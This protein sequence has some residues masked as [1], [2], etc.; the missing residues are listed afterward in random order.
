MSAPSIVYAL[1]MNGGAVVFVFLIRSRT[2]LQ[3]L[4]PHL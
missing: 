4:E 1:L 3:R 2:R